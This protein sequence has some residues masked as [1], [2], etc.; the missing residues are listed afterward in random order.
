MKDNF[1]SPVP[2]TTP[3]LFI[4][5]NRPDNYSEGIQCNKAG[6]TETAFYCS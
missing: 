4:I 5:F 1:I 3:V 6:K 2:L